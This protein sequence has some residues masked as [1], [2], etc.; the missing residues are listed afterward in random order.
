[1]RA[2][3]LARKIVAAD[4]AQKID[5]MFYSPNRKCFCR[6]TLPLTKPWPGFRLPEW[7]FLNN[8]PQPANYNYMEPPSRS[9]T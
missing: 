4:I 7:A 2:N 1:M 3:P 5:Y 6:W 9:D 8:T